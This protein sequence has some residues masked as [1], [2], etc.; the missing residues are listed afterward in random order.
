MKEVVKI[1]IKLYPSAAI[2]YV[3]QFGLQEIDSS[4]PSIKFP[5]AF[6]ISPRPSHPNFFLP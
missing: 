1:V 2:W 5:A 4:E 6:P 3:K